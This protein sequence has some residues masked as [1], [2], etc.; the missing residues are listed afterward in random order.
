V[1]VLVRDFFVAGRVPVWQRAPHGK[2]G[3]EVPVG[4]H[5]LAIY[6]LYFFGFS[7][8]YIHFLIKKLIYVKMYIF[9]VTMCC[10]VVT[11]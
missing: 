2:R 4:D 8:F 6:L 10:S 7:I 1:L 5:H 9:M 11:V 3:W